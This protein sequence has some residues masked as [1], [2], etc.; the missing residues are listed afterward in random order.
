[1][2][3]YDLVS[4]HWDFWTYPAGTGTYF[5][6][7]TFALVTAFPHPTILQTQSQGVAVALY[8]SVHTDALLVGGVQVPTPIVCD[9]YTDTFDG[10]TRYKKFLSRTELIGDQFQ[11]SSVQLRVSDDDYKTWSNFRTLD[12]SQNRAMLMNCG[13]FRKRAWHLR[14]TANTPLR[15][16]A[17]ELEMILG[18]A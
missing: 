13:T 16:E 18:T 3:V 14:H 10:G 6:G 15:L 1:M 2:L 8:D 5:C 11:G 12:L 9:M 7:S 17:L 4:Q